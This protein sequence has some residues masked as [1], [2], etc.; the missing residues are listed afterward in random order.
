M[1]N[2]NYSPVPF[3]CSICKDPRI[4]FECA[5]Q[6]IKKVEMVDKVYLIAETCVKRYCRDCFEEYGG[7]STDYA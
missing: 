3:T 1:S 5:D 4:H 7:N 6:W 2:V